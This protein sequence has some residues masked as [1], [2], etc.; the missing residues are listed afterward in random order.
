MQTKSVTQL[1]STI[2]RYVH[3]TMARQ[4]EKDNVWGGKGQGKL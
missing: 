1:I 4:R 3:G 2:A